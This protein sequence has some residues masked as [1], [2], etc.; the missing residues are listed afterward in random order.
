MNTSRIRTAPLALRVLLAGLVALALAGCSTKRELVIASEPAGARVWVNGEDK[1][2][3]PARIPFVYYGTF[4]VR[5]EKEGYEAW[6]GEVPVKEKIDGYPVID[7][8]FELTY[9][10]RTFHWRGVLE[11][12]TQESDAALQELVR[13]ASAFRERTLREARPDP[14]PAPQPAPQRGGSTPPR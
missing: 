12:T 14:A 4:D 10:K 13:E 8:P 6:A 7:L 5:L 9:R 1:G 2:R 3:T 11:R